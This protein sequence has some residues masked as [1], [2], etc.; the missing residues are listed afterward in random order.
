MS[1]ERYLQDAFAQKQRAVSLYF[2]SE[3]ACETIGQYGMWDIKGLASEANCPYYFLEY[4]RDNWIGVT[5]GTTLYGQIYPEES[6][7]TSGVLAVTC[8]R[9]EDN[10]LPS[11][12]ARD[13]PRALFVDDLAICFNWRSLDTIDTSTADSKCHIWMDGK[14]LFQVCSPPQVQSHTFHCTLIQAS[15]ACNCE[16]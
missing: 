16:D 13:I 10:E 6:V 9:L 14:V 11:C 8:F 12:I 4:L 3:K 2:D 1:L 15:E 5:I 7:P